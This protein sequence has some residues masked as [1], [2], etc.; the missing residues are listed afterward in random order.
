MWTDL[1]SSAV[2]RSPRAARRDRVGGKAAALARLSDAG[3]P[4]PAWVVVTPEAFDAS[5][6]GQW[7]DDVGL[8]PTIEDELGDALREI[9]GAV[10]TFAVRSSAVDEDSREHSFAG[11]LESYLF[12]P[13]AD[14]PRRIVDVWRSAFTERVLAYRRE[15][16]LLAP[17]SVPGVL[18]QQMVDADVSGV[19]FSADPVTG[20][21]DTVVVGS[22]YGLG[23]A[24][25]SGD[26][27]ADTHHVD[28]RGHVVGR[29][30]VA[31]TTAHRASS[32]C[33][34][35][36]EAVDVEPERVHRPALRDEQITAVADL[37]R[38]AEDFF[39]C[40]QDIEWAI[41][42][43]QLF[44][45]QSRPITSLGRVVEPVGA[46]A[47]WDNSNIVESYAGITTPLTF[48]FARNAYQGVY[49]QLCRIF[50]VPA[51]R[52]EANRGALAGM[53]GLI[54][55][56]IYYNLLNWYRLL[57][58][59]PGYQ[60][61]RAFL[62]QMIGVKEGAS[63]GLA[64]DDEPVPWTARLLDGV[65][66]IRCVAGMTFS[67][68]A[69][70]V[71]AKRFHRRVDEV[72][73]SP[74]G[75]LSALRAD[76]LAAEYRRVEDRL[77]THWDAPQINDF[78]AMIFYGVLRRL[79]ARWC[80]DTDGTLQNG[81][82]SGSGGMVSTEPAERV[83]E[84][85]AIAR[86]HPDLA[87][88]LGDPEAGHSLEVVARHPEFRDRYESYL[89]KF[90]DRCADELKLES[91]T[92]RED[93]LMLLR[94]IGCLA[95]SG[96]AE[97]PGEPADSAARREAEQRVRATLAARPVRRSVL[98]WVLSETRRLVRGREN[99][100]L[101]RT[102]VFGRVRAIFVELGR[103]L[104]DL[105]LLDDP[106]DVFYLE[107]EEILGFVDGTSVS[108]NLAEVASARKKE[109]AR[110]AEMEPPAD[111]FETRGPVNHGN[112]FRSP[113]D[114]GE[115]RGDERTGVGCCPGKVSGRVRVVRDPRTATLCPG[116]I[117][118]AERTDPSWVMLF[119]LAKGL[120]VERGSLLSHSAIVAREMG[121]PA[122]VS[123]A[124]V[125]RWLEDGDW[126]ELDGTSGRLRRV[127]PSEES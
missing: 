25:V 113:S 126:V 108:T 57:A 26:A 56:R 93:P 54:R 33:A 67:F 21:R 77:I 71:R 42:S 88:A 83:K 103:R 81:L 12:V 120:L 76:E 82:L 31:K 125:T 115:V 24:L 94:S 7:H 91:R 86:R 51:K 119:P 114:P 127:N 92:L 75:G 35:G 11:Q 20:D 6:T 5:V 116:E 90:G 73:S 14:V 50:A 45:L 102:R 110:F 38:R 27:E 59:L 15:R 58:M 80:G 19:A 46:L 3:F 37:A 32:R 62:E 118:V 10:P 16:D 89:Q 30:V 64:E 96:D 43:G 66:V 122:I 74:N 111:R 34:E 79:C 28:R 72:L 109:F 60:M 17:P 100:R 44:L 65:H 22:L 47:I 97:E 101:Q 104:H 13:I 8:E 36:V 9:A 29:R 84:M 69:L 107:M 99:M 78:F 2:I 106:R 55:G 98:R 63:D 49:G 39:G 95:R 87:N 61:N 52:V 117:L 85:A 41:A 23:T 40:P 53:L 112:T 18:V 124:G 123:V 4:V 121:I 68:L 105:R 48:T 1:E 70:P